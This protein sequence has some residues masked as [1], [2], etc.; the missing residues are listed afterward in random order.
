MDTTIRTKGTGSIFKR[1]KNGVELKNF[2]LA[3][4]DRNGRQI[5]ESSGSSIKAV[6]ERKLRTKLA[7]VEKGVPVEQ[8]RRLKY[9]DIRD[10]LLTKYKNNKVGLFTRR[11]SVYGIAYLDEFFANMLVININT[12]L[13]DEFAANSNA[14]CIAR[15]NPPT[16]ARFMVHLTPPSIAYSPYCVR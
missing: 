5:Q 12:P 9:E 6:A 7:D 14:R 1:S 11:K 4:Y 13:L 15:P 2:Y 3:Y 16:N 10:S 8:A